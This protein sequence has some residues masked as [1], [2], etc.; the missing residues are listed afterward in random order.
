MSSLRSCSIAP[1][2]FWL[3][4]TDYSKYRGPY[5]W[6]YVHTKNTL[7]G[8]TL[9]TNPQALTSD[10]HF[11]G[12]NIS[13]GLKVV[14]I[15]KASNVGKGGGYI[16]WARQVELELH[17]ISCMIVYIVGQPLGLLGGRVGFTLRFGSKKVGVQNNPYQT[18]LLESRLVSW[19]RSIFSGRD[20]QIWWEIDP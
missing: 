19:T 8:C 20:C 17:I 13:I 1:M 18:I 14:C 12:Y 15:W 9:F 11:V 2:W 10:V 7:C 16:M 6:A 5:Y 3:Q 4:Y